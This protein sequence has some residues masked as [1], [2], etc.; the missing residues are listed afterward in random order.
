VLLQALMS[1]VQSLKQQ[2]QTL[3]DL[4]HTAVPSLPPS[5]MSGRRS[6]SVY[7]EDRDD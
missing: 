1:E 3:T 6:V 5:P 4:L 7:S 2:V